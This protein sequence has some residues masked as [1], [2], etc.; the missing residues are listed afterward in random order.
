MTL[1]E[2]NN[3]SENK[4]AYQKVLFY[5]GIEL[6][7]DGNYQEALKMFKKSI[8]NSKTE[9]FTTRATFWKGETEYVLDNFSDALSSFKE[10]E[11]SA[12][13]KATPE[14]KNINYNI[15][16][17][18]FKLKQYDQAG[19]YFQKHIDVVKEDKTR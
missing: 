15:A 11:N 19:D 4:S 13:A 12:E 7:T 3:T 18:H 17:A 8:T 10:F 1:L 2:K 9:K 14:F 6:F 5:R 16:Y